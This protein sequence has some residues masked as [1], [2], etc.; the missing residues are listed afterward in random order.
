MFES[1]RENLNTY[2][3]H[4][5]AKLRY[6]ELSSTPR[7]LEEASEELLRQ[8]SAIGLPTEDFTRGS[9]DINWNR[10]AM[11]PQISIDH[12]SPKT[13]K[14]HYDAFLCH[15]SAYLNYDGSRLRIDLDVQLS[16]VTASTTVSVPL[17]PSDRETLLDI[18]R[19]QRS[20][21]YNEPSYYT[22]C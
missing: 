7:L 10:Q 8:L 19:I 9:P 11:R 13:Y 15:P 18:G 2:R 1:L 12:S 6:L 17:A 3:K 21:P 22:T 16:H 5:E 4:N 14:E 20:D